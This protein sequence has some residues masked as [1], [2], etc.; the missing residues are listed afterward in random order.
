MSFRL[1]QTPWFD[2]LTN[3][4]RVTGQLSCT[5]RPGSQSKGRVHDGSYAI[6][7]LWFDKLTNHFRVTGQ[8]AYTGLPR[9]LSQSK[10][11]VNDGS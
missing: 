1:L 4:F 8:P 3:L 7:M 5:D 9:S 2:K 6:Q 11:R 10:G